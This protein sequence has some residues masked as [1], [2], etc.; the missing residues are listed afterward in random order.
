M[1][2]PKRNHLLAITYYIE[3]IVD[4]GLIQFYTEKNEQFNY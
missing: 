1:T 2:E 4:K 3:Q